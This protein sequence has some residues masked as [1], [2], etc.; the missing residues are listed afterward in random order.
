M[1]LPGC[2]HPPDEAFPSASLSSPFGEQRSCVAPPGDLG[3]GAA[4]VPRPALH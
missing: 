2:S 3:S 1:R 4:R